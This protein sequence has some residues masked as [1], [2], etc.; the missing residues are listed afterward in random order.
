[1]GVKLE[2]IVAVLAIVITCSTELLKKGQL[3]SSKTGVE[4]PLR[5]PHIYVVYMAESWNI[6]CAST[7]FSGHNGLPIVLFYKAGQQVIRGGRWVLR[8]FKIQ[9]LPLAMM[10]CLQ[11]ASPHQGLA[12][13]L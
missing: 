9:S 7:G 2:T 10:H 4:T 11:Q 1:M 12:L 3:L 8:S 13:S 5:N 6:S